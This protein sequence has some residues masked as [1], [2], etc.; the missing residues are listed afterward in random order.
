MFGRL[1]LIGAVIAFAGVLVLGAGHR[2][3]GL[4]LMGCGLAL[5]AA[6]AIIER[7]IRWG[8]GLASSH[9]G[10]GAQLRGMAMIVCAAALF[11]AAA[12]ELTNRGTLQEAIATRKGMS[13][14]T[15][16]LGVAAMFWG[17]ADMLGRS[18]GRQA[19][20]A[21]VS[22]PSRIFG[23]LIVIAGAVA[24]TFAVLRLLAGR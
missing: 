21:L 22:L 3:W 9:V 10:I 8:L 13:V 19:M 7:E 1:P 24:A 11:C 15:A 12:W 14:L 20:G 17:S 16:F 2:A 18:R 6:H 4:F 23:F 5:L